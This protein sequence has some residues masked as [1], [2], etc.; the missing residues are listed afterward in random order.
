VIVTHFF[1]SAGARSRLEQ[2]QNSTARETLSD[3]ALL[4]RQ[5]LEEKDYG[6]LLQVCTCQTFY[7]LCPLFFRSC[8][9]ECARL[10]LWA[11]ATTEGTFL[12]RLNCSTKVSA[13]HVK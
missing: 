1:I 13:T 11:P 2:L 7:F 5:V 6:K 4:L 10:L 12:F 8:S 3:A 9:S